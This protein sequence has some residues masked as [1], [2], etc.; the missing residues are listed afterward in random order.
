MDQDT[1]FSEFSAKA[2]KFFDDEIVHELPPGSSAN[3]GQM[4]I[5]Y[6]GFQ[7]G[8]S[9]LNLLQ[10]KGQVGIIAYLEYQDA[11]N[12][13]PEKKYFLFQYPFGSPKLYSLIGADYRKIYPRLKEQLQTE[14]ENELLTFIRN[15]PPE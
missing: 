3:F 15:N 9:P 11:I 10:S 6:T 5:G 14:G 13:N 2:A 8:K 12:I 4:Q 1:I 7:N